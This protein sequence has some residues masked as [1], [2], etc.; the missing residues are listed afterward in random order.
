MTAQRTDAGQLAKRFIDASIEGRS[1]PPSKAA[2][3][4]GLKLA[5]Q[6]IEELTRVAQRSRGRG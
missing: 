6:A 2:Y 4:R 1:K 3:A 5:H